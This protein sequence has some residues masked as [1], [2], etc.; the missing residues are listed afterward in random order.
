MPIVNNITKMQQYR[1]GW[2][3][4]KEV[5]PEAVYIGRRMHAKGLPQSPLANP[6]LI[7]PD[8]DR[9][10]VIEKYRVWLWQRI[11]LGD[12]AVLDALEAIE[13]HTRLVC[14]CA[15]QRCH[16]EIVIKAWDWLRKHPDEIKRAQVS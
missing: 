3:R 8:G 14:W 6:F 1:D 4:I 10:Q 5:Y 16:G 11:K 7:G 9:E 15:P 12:N 2:V 13:P